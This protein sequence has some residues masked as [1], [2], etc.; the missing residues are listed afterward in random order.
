MSETANRQ[1]VNTAEGFF[2]ALRSPDLATAMSMLR[3]VAQNPGAALAFGKVNDRDIVDEL[4]RQSNQKEGVTFL[5]VVFG[6]LAAF[7]DPRAVEHFVK[8]LHTWSNPQIVRLA[9]ARLTHEPVESIEAKVRPLLMQDQSPLH[10]TAAADILIPVRTLTTE[11]RVRI[12]VANSEGVD[13]GPELS[14]ET[15]RSWAHALTGWFAPQARL[16]LSSRD[17]D[18]VPALAP[19]WDDLDV[20]SKNW[21]LALGVAKSPLEVIPLL[22]RAL[23]DAEPRVVLGALSTLQ[24]MEAGKALFVNALTPLLAHPEPKIRC[25]AI[26]AGARHKDWRGFLAGETEPEVIVW[27]ARRLAEAEGDAALDTLE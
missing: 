1:V 16:V 8:V 10:A 14:A 17:E 6:A 13:I 2:G 25:L 24:T 22:R 20:D 18:A 26:Q 12:T 15:A 19:L 11:E 5:E 3:A 4:I 23:G 7:D 27:A 9:A 21:L